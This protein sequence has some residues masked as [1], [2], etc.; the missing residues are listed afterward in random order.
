MEVERITDCNVAE[1]WFKRDHRHFMSLYRGGVHEKYPG[2]DAVQKEDQEWA[3]ALIRAGCTDDVDGSAPVAVAPP[4]HVPASAPTQP[5]TL[6]VAADRDGGY[7]LPMPRT[8]S[9]SMLRDRFRMPQSRSSASSSSAAPVVKQEPGE[10]L[11]DA[12]M[13]RVAQEMEY[14]QAE[15]PMAIED[16]PAKRP[17]REGA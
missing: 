5:N 17:K 2:Y 13:A 12:E 6:R 9:G 14:F 7:R 1:D 8:G 4:T 11:S 3:N 10:P 16:S 15:G